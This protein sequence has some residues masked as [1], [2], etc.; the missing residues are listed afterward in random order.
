MSPTSLRIIAFKQPF[1]LSR[2]N[3]G[4]WKIFLASFFAQR[5]SEQNNKCHPPKHI[6]DELNAVCI[7]TCLNILCAKHHQELVCEALYTE[8]NVSCSFQFSLQLLDNIKSY[9]ISFIIQ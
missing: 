8:I 9:E 4:F 2:S 5:K 6:L 1:V 3:L 7:L